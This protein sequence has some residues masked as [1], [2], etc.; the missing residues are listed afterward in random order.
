[1]KTTII[2]I[3]TITLFCN[4]ISAQFY[5]DIFTEKPNVDKMLV[6]DSSNVRIW[7]ALNATDI[8][9]Q[10]T[11]DDLQRLEIGSHI[12]K[13]YSHFVFND[14]SLTTVWP[15]EHP[16][17]KHAPPNSLG[18]KGK[19]KIWSEYYYSEYFKDFNKNLLT[20]YIRMP[21]DIPNQQYS[22][23]ISI[24]SWKILEDTLTV[25]GYLCQ[26]ATCRFRGINYTAW[27]AM[28]IPIQ[29]GPWKFGGLPGLILKAYDS[30]KLYMFECVKIE[31]FK[32]KHPIKIHNYYNNFEK[33]NRQKLHKFL[34]RIYADYYN[35]AGLI[36]NRLDG[37]PILWKKIP[38][39]P[40]ELE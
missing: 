8:K 5:T 35:T 33:T 34:E 24:Q 10:E 2:L 22:E 37:T 32:K 31:S 27:F 36:V 28:D 19:K 16:N 11:Y 13:Y 17:A 26:K 1:M 6:I 29:N 18:E 39:N 30:D 7:Y 4:N 40:L 3:I 20:Q 9:K 21:M 15:K 23:S 14:D 12:S 25:A 38:Y